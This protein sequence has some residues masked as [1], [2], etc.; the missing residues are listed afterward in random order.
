MDQLA[1]QD[2]PSP[3]GH[4]Y[5][6]ETVDYWNA[7]VHGVDGDRALSKGQLVRASQ[8]IHNDAVKLRKPAD[9]FPSKYGY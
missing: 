1:S 6:D 7:V 2:V 9:G 3:H 4:N 8:W 5:H